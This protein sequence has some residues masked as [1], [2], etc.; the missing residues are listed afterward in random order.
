MRGTR[1]MTGRAVDKRFKAGLDAIDEGVSRHGAL[2]MPVTELL[3]RC[4]RFHVADL[5]EI[6]GELGRRGIDHEPRDLG[7]D[8]RWKNVRLSR[9][10]APLDREAAG[11]RRYAVASNEVTLTADATIAPNATLWI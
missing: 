2:P 9:R 1:P 8:A 3:H 7:A 11:I 6:L 4:G 10:G 5:D